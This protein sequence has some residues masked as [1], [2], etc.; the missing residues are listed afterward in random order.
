MAFIFG[1]FVAFIIGEA[2]IESRHNK[3]EIERL[4]K[5]LDSMKKLLDSYKEWKK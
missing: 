1:V 2:Y 3:R 4:E 5:R